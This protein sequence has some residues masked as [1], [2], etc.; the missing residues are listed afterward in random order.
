[1][2]DPI[3]PREPGV[4]SNA[5][6]VGE[7]HECRLLVADHELLTLARGTD[8]D[9]NPGNPAREIATYLLLVEAVPLDPVGKTL[10]HQRPIFQVGKNPVGYALVVI[11]ELALGKP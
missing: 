11:N 1:M 9:A 6:L 4:Q 3:R 2:T 7:I 10:Q 8:L 5:R